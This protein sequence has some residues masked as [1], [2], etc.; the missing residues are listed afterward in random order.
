MI[1]KAL[2]FELVRFK[3]HSPSSKIPKIPEF[4]LLMTVKCGILR[5][6]QI[7]YPGIFN[8]SETAMNRPLKAMTVYW[9]IEVRDATDS[10]AV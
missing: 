1:F 7:F 8:H 5:N 10:V 6:V 3:F 4:N 2:Q 9:T